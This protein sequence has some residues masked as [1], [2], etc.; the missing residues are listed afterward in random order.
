MKPKLRKE[1]EFSSEFA[2]R[3]PDVFEFRKH[4]SLEFADFL[5]NDL[6]LSL[7]DHCECLH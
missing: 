4:R 7:L 2:L 6:S 5:V 1:T 3:C